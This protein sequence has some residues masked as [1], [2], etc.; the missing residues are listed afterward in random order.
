[1]GAY[2]VAMAYLQ[3]TDYLVWCGEHKEISQ[4]SYHERLCMGSLQKGL[5]QSF[6]AW[7]DCHFR[8]VIDNMVDGLAGGRNHKMEDQLENYW[9]SPHKV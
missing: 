8:K 5:R 6:M 7:T 4:G 9:R 1:M 3:S 2:D